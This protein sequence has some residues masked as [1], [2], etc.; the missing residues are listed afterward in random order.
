MNGLSDFLNQ[1]MAADLGA[2]TTN[3]NSV[4]NTIIGLLGVGVIG[5][6]IFLAYK[7]FT[8]SDEQKRKDAKGQMIYAIVGIIV[9]VV[10]LVLW[11]T[12]LKNALNPTDYNPSTGTG[13]NG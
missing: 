6:T 3:I 4:A 10:I 13:N 12:V 9:V 11:N 8:A 2:V 5:V 1:M 7:F